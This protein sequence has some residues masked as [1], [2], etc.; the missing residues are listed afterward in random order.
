[1]ACFLLVFVCCFF[2]FI[3]K[4]NVIQESGFAK[5]TEAHSSLHR[6]GKKTILRQQAQRAQNHCATP[7]VR[8][9]GQ[10]YVHQ[11]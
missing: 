8:S 10:T 7:Q 2:F 11:C 1:M 5:E 4:V 9:P 3:S 6:K